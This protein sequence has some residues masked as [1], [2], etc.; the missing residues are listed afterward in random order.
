[1]AYPEETPPLTRR[2]AKIFKK[3]LNS[4]KLNPEQEQM[5]RE[6]KRG[7]E[8][9]KDIDIED[10]ETLKQLDKNETYVFKLKEDVTE[11]AIHYLQLFCEKEGIH[12]IIHRGEVEI[13]EK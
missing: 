6:A 7:G 3:K 9:M 12:A 8:K 13:K 5:F 1:M 2:E 4:F 11:S 10:I